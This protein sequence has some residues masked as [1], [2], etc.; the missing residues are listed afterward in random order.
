[1]ISNKPTIL[2]VDDSENDRFLVRA[3]FKMNHCD[4]LLQEARNGEEAI[5]YLQGDGP[6]G[7]RNNYPLPVVM[8]LDLN[9]PKKNGFE[10]LAWV[11][12]QPLLKRLA[13]IIL[14]ASARDEDVERA[15]DLGATSYLVKPSK[16]ETLSAI[17]R[18]LCDWIQFNRFPPL[19]A[20]G[21][22]DIDTG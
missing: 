11:R 9:M 16:L 2:L 17:E 14:T 21:R 15:Y 12:V 6:F 1:M 4:I 18:C 22:R 19:T 8:L 10:V 7:D 3:V 5:A 20:A 13:V